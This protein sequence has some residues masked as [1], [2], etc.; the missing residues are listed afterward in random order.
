[1]FASLLSSEDLDVNEM[2]TAVLLSLAIEQ[3]RTT[4][5]MPRWRSAICL[6]F[7]FQKKDVKRRMPI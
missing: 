6:A 4:L 3:Q 1:M 5:C 7:L 2:L